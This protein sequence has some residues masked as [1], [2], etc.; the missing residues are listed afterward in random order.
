MVGSIQFTQVML[1]EPLLLRTSFQFS[2][3]V[4]YTLNYNNDI[5]GTTTTNGWRWVVVVVSR[6]IDYCG[7][8]ASKLQA[9]IVVV[10][11]C[12]CVGSHGSVVNSGWLVD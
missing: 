2:M 3:P 8:I 6:D 12:G 11:D 4:L 5:G 9:V 7:Q 1:F 10:C